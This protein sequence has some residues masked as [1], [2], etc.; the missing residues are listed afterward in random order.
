MRRRARGAVGSLALA[1]LLTALIGAA[2]GGGGAEPLP[3]DDRQQ[4]QPDQMDPSDPQEQQE[5]E[6]G[7]DAAEPEVELNAA[8]VGPHLVWTPWQAALPGLL[9]E[10]SD[11][12]LSALP[13]RSI[14][15][16]GPPPPD[17]GVLFSPSESSSTQETFWM[18]LIQDVSAESAVDWV[19]YLGSLEAGAALGFLSPQHQLVAA[20]WRPP[21][22]IGGSSLAGTLWH[23][24]EGGTYRSDLVVFSVGAT[25]IFLRSA[26]EVGGETGRALDAMPLTDI[27]AVAALVEQRLQVVK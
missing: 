18:Y 1:A 2:C 26:M 3:P 4:E 22:M 10:V 11:P 15:R 13:S 7:Q 9:S 5:V 27:D 20:T 16:W 12:V 24:H 8:D 19:V 14:A 6:S 23:G 21:P 25:L 17:P